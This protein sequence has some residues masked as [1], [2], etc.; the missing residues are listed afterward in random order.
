MVKNSLLALLTEKPGVKNK[1]TVGFSPD[2]E[3]S[4][5]TALELRGKIKRL[6]SGKEVPCT[7][8]CFSTRYHSSRDNARAKRKVFN[9]IAECVIPKEATENILPDLSDRAETA[10]ER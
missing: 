7:P 6:Y 2:C 1:K 9:N 3:E 5:L 8:L 4:P 10:K